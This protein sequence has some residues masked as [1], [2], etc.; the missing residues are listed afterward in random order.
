MIFSELGQWFIIITTAS[1][2]FG[3]KGHEIKSAADAARALEPLVVGFPN[4]GLMA[5][6]IFAIGIIGLGLL[7]IP[8][9]AGSAAYA[10]SEALGWREGLN[11]KFKEARGFYGVII[12]ATLIGLG[13]NFVGIDPMKALFYTAVF[14]GMAAVPLIFVIGLING[15]SDI[16]GS[17]KGGFLSQGLIW[18]CFLIMGAS[19]VALALSFGH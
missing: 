5:K 13:L 19:L 1:V 14:N 18:L 7:G 4:A 2:L 9:L 6:I 11:R 10:L 17:R 16:L 8:V 12:V 15:R 3:L